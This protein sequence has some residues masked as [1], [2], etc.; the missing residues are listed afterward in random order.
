[1][2]MYGRN[3]SW[4]KFKAICRN[5]PEEPEGTSGTKINALAKIHSRYIWV[6]YYKV[7]RFGSLDLRE[8]SD[9]EYVGISFIDATLNLKSVLLLDFGYKLDKSPPIC[10]T[11][12]SINRSFKAT[13]LNSQTFRFEEGAGP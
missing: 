13:K 2:T 6:K 3:L 9:K 1:M 5:L 12:F 4:P 11:K 10:L 8:M 7:Y